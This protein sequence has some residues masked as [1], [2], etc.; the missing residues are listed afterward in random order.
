MYLNLV[1]R[2]HLSVFITTHEFISLKTPL[3]GLTQSLNL[4]KTSS[5]YIMNYLNST[6]L[7]HT[8]LVG[9]SLCSITHFQTCLLLF[10]LLKIADI[11]QAKMQ[12]YLHGILRKVAWGL[13]SWRQRVM[14]FTISRNMLMNFPSM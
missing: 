1:P 7:R 5:V 11:L 4:N 10:L 8:P 6:V 2:L 12:I 9:A 14:F 3:P 13:D